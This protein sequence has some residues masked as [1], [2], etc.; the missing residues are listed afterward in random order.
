MHTYIGFRISSD[1]FQHKHDVNIKWNIYWILKFWYKTW[2]VCPFITKLLFMHWVAS[3][4]NMLRTGEHLYK[5][6]NALAVHAVINAGVLMHPTAH[7][8]Q[9]WVNIL[10]LKLFVI[11]VDKQI[12]CSNQS[13]TFW[14]PQMSY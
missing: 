5:S 1:L 7:N 9:D 3:I 6:Q 12:L 8:I 4:S 11:T 14:K 2:L 10:Y 13:K